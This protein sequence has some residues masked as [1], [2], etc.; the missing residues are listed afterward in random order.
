MAI[1]RSF[2][3][4]KLILFLLFFAVC[5]DIK[6]L[7]RSAEASRLSLSGKISIDEEEV[8]AKI[9]YSLPE[10]IKLACG[11]GLILDEA[12]VSSPHLTYSSKDY[13]AFWGSGKTKDSMAL[14]VKPYSVVSAP[15]DS[16]WFACEEGAK[17]SLLFGFGSGWLKIFVLAV[18]KSIQSEVSVD[19]DSDANASASSRMF[20]ESFR[21]AGIE[22]S[23]TAET[24]SFAFSASLA[25]RP[26]EVSGD[27]W[28]AGASFTPGSTFFT[29]ASAARMALGNSRAGAWVS[30]SAGYLGNPGLAASLDWAYGRPI[31]VFGSNLASIGTSFSV[32]ASSR[33]Y[34]TVSGEASLYDFLADAK[35][36]IKG[37]AWNF[38]A[39]IMAGSLSEDD[40]SSGKQALIR[41]DL[42]AVEALLW[43]W[44]T[45]LLSVAVDAGL[46]AFSLAS[47]LSAD[48][49]GWR[50]GSLSLRYSQTPVDSHRLTFRAAGKLSFSRNGVDED[51]TATENDDEED[52]AES[53]GL[54]PLEWLTN[55]AGDS[56]SLRS[57]GGE[58]GLRWVDSA[59]GTW[60]GQGSV[61]IGVSAK[62]TDSLFSFSISGELTQKILVLGNLAVT[63][64]LKSPEGGYALDALPARFPS[65][66]MG[67][68]TARD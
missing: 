35:A 47:R 37:Q 8:I 3:V 62:R 15:S 64:A 36:S 34:R 56:I 39:R 48:A 20:N 4:K 29:L 28:R 44:R 27:G 67:F 54:S 40:S 50:S 53:G 46:G 5:G 58:C 57:I 42:R 23:K 12:T 32:F 66:T 65:L 33:P 45:D 13:V 52:F 18:P 14:K 63:L 2:Y 68:S 49:G 43:L 9:E 21:A 6:G 7:P 55:S 61:K 22:L 41:E 10:A 51:A 31:K 38:T 11:V 25:D 30:G 59:S 17:N 60:L 24:L 26:A 19:S 1:S 16:L